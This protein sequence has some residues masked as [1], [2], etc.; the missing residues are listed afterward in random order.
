LIFSRRC[1]YY[2]IC[3][4]P[5]RGRIV[6]RYTYTYGSGIK[7][8]EVSLPRPLSS[9]QPLRAG[10]KQSTPI[11]ETSRHRARGPGQRTTE[12][13]SSSWPSGRCAGP[14]PPPPRPLQH[15]QLH[16]KL[17]KTTNGCVSPLTTT[18][19]SSPPSSSCHCFTENRSPRTPCP[20]A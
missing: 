5:S 4:R 19:N 11:R 18:F 16:P 7:Q 20:G 14:L 10:R 13:P 15:W 9:I 3:G 17:N 8:S 6:A 1:T 12:A 2:T